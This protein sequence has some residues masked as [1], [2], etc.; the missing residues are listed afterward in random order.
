MAKKKFYAV[1]KGRATGI[2]DTW[3]ECKNSVGGFSGA[4]YKSFPTEAEARAYLEGDRMQ[5][6]PE[7]REEI[8]DSGLIAYVD[9]SFDPALGKYA[10][11]CILITPE[12]EE[13]RRSGNGSDPEAVAIRNVAGEMLGAMQAVRWAERNGYDSLVIFYDYEG[14]EKWATGAWS[15]KNS[16]TQKYAGFMKDSSRKVR[17]VFQKVKAHSGDYYNEQVDKLARGALRDV[18]NGGAGEER[19]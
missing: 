11:G 15:A 9:G 6:S 19:I 2:F 14:I 12:G 18:E 8:L 17:V 5:V 13:I 4:E 3:E 16:L 7:E 1:R 10:F